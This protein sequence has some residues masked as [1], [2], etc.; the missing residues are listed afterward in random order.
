MEP[1]RA[2][3][4]CAELSLS[5][6]EL[7]VSNDK[8]LLCV[9]RFHVVPASTPMVAALPRG[10]HSPRVCRHHPI[11]VHPSSSPSTAPNILKQIWRRSQRCSDPPNWDT[12]SSPSLRESPDQRGS[13]LQSISMASSGPAS[14]V[15]CP[16]YILPAVLPCLLMGIAIVGHCVLAGMCRNSSNEQN[17]VF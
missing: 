15:Q 7:Q 13:S 5:C 16:S 3:Q 9:S 14:K 6:S 12:P 11:H 2:P 17:K 1:S 4:A 10:W 8:S